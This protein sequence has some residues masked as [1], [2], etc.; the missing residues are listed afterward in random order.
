MIAMLD[1]NDL[2][3]LTLIATLWILGAI[4]LRRS[5]D[6]ER[7]GGMARRPRLDLSNRPARPPLGR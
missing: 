4:A 1:V 7:P 2:L 6:D 5:L 3:A